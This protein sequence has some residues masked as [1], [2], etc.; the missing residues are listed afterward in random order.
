MTTKY[1]VIPCHYNT[2]STISFC[3]KISK[4]EIQLKQTHARL[5]KTLIHSS[6]QLHQLLTQLLRLP[7]KKLSYARNLFDQIPHSEKNECIWTSLI[8]AHT[9]CDE[10]RWAILIYRRM[11][12]MGILESGFTFSSVLNACARIPAVREGKMIH[13]RVIESG[14]TG[15]KVIG[16][17][18][19]DM[20]GKCGLIEDARR[21]FDEMVDRDVVAWTAMVSGYTKMGLMREA[22]ALF[23]VMQERNVVSWTSMVAGYANLGEIS[24]AKVLYDQMPIR[25]SI[26]WIAMIA[27]YGKVGDVLG[28]EK[29]FNEIVA[30]DE[31][32]WGA[33]IA[34]YSH[35]GYLN[36]AIE[37]YKRMRELNVKANEVAMVG[38]ISACTQLGDVEMAHSLAEHVEEGSCDRTLILSNALI[39]MYAKCASI[40]QALLEF[41]TM[42]ERDIITYGALITALA[43]H[44]RPQEALE[45]F[46]KM[47]KEGVTPNKVT[48]LGVLNACS[49]AGL[50]EQGYKYFKQLTTTFKIE[51]STEHIACMVDL[52]GRAGKLNEAYK[53]IA[54]NTG[55]KRDAGAWGALLGACAVH[56][57][58]QLG[59]I[60]AQH[61]FQIEPENS[62]NYVLLANIYASVHRW[63]DAARVRTRLSERRMSKTV[64]YSWISNEEEYGARTL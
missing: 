64:G 62:G 56:G 23:D 24:E 9:L 6:H 55:A 52:L 59:E 54:E 34:C 12:E 39:H 28:A 33:M 44:G 8:R 63:D 21:V 42:R 46:S 41:N 47:Q 58:V 15:S 50:V 18:L 25:N 20:Y 60:S 43:D 11:H 17:T 32:S 1:F 14:F 16:T 27:G 40:D 29:V 61:L 13:A 35:N 57:N 22:R 19:V 3:L 31:S 48:F 2:E 49:Y 30:K 53:I 51:P 37:M 38:V 7:F 4:T 10:F 5:L 36:Q 26:T 45:L